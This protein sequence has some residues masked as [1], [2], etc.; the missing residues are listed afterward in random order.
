MVTVAARSG[1]LRTV[2]GIA[3]VNC[4]LASRVVFVQ[5][6]NVLWITIQ[7]VLRMA[8]HTVIC[9]ECDTPRVGRESYCV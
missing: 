3:H 5:K 2:L 6:K 4:I 1:G 8:G 9:V 7:C